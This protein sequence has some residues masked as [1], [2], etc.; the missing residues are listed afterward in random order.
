MDINKKLKE[1]LKKYPVYPAYTEIEYQDS[2]NNTVSQ[3]LKKIGDSC[4][5]V[6]TSPYDINEIVLKNNFINWKYKIL[7]SL[8]ELTCNL[9]EFKQVIFI[10]YENHPVWVNNL[11]KKYHRGKILDLYE[12]LAGLGFKFEQEYY[13][14]SKNKRDPYADINSMRKELLR[15]NSND[16]MLL[17]QKLI[18]K[19]IEI[20]DFKNAF[21]FMDKYIKS[22][23]NNFIM[24]IN[25]KDA[26]EKMFIEIKR[27]LM[28]RRQ[29]SIIM[30]WVDSVQYNEME[31]MPFLYRERERTLCFDNAYTVSPFT[32][33]TYFTL[34]CQK[35]CVRDKLPKYKHNI[36]TKK[37]S[38]LMELLD[39]NNYIF[40]RHGIALNIFENEN[41]GYGVLMNDSLENDSK[42]RKYNEIKNYKELDCKED[43]CPT[44]LWKGLRDITLYEK[45]FV[46]VHIDAE[47]HT[48][49]ICGN[50]DGEYVND[51]FSPNINQIAS[52]RV[53]VDQQL[54]FYSQIWGEKIISIIMSDHGKVVFG[55]QGKMYRDLYHT[56]LMIKGSGIKKMH[57]KK[58][59]SYLN[60][61]ELIKHFLHPEKSSWDKLFQDYIEI[62]DLDKYGLA[63]VTQ[64]VNQDC[65]IDKNSLLGYQ[66]IRTTDKMFVRRNDGKEMYF[67][68][69]CIVDQ[70]GIVD[71]TEYSHLKKLLP[72][73]KI[74]I[75]DDFFTYT[76]VIYSAIHS[77][78][79]RV[80]KMQKKADLLV[81]KLFDSFSKTNVIA[82]RGGGEATNEIIRHMG[83]N[84]PVKYIIDNSINDEEGLPEFHYITM[85]EL[86][87][88]SI[89]IIIITSYNFKEEM[90]REL[91]RKGYFKTKCQIIDLYQYFYENGLELDE[92]YHADKI[93][94]I[95]MKQA[96]EKLRNHSK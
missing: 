22:Q 42:L 95:D 38:K 40:F 17:T 57:C 23:Y 37:N 14:T 66:A 30:C 58:M 89:D 61:Y 47:T 85:D 56:M 59:F 82:L 93:S 72:E 35:R 29:N 52:A 54:E 46:L 13:E 55:K 7:E 87:Q 69:P 24:M 31:E 44:V 84:N 6:A 36:I 25:L 3:I 79:K 76:R 63:V 96:Y 94:A 8:D 74:N 48:P 92:D 88:F 68:F 27:E 43:I 41:C 80:E 39:E 18:Y 65:N 10:S 86:E 64:F 83:N 12:I 2:I 91:K 62:E 4:F 71:R 5:A 90:K 9:D 60:F 19:Y 51:Q 70:C 26:L 75:K 50:Y 34:F 21:F 15:C 20:R 78:D 32:I 45:V 49:Y 53:Y 11:Q 16:Q 1:I 33:P 28:N 77:H 73:Y 81:E 67:K